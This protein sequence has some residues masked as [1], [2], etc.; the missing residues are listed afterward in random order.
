ME[1]F[2]M[3]PRW[4]VSFEHGNTV[5]TVSPQHRND[6]ADGWFALFSQEQEK[7]L[8]LMERGFA[9]TNQEPASITTLWEM[10]L[11]Q[12][13]PMQLYFEAAIPLVDGREWCEAEGD[14]LKLNI[15]V[16]TH[17][18]GIYRPRLDVIY[19]WPKEHQSVLMRERPLGLTIHGYVH[20]GEV[21][22]LRRS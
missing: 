7:N 10:I 14:V 22:L 2:N 12:D 19:L 5:L 9:L 18:T 3:T 17:H 1:E 16:A 4:S 8:V 15:S 11:Y 20:H 13:V 21:S 6:L